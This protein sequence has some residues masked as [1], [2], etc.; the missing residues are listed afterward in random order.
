MSET[1][2]PKAKRAKK[3][4][5]AKAVLAQGGNRLP[6]RIRE[7]ERILRQHV[8]LRKL[9]SYLKASLT[10]AEAYA[11]VEC[12]GPHLFQGTTGKLY[13]IHPP[14]AYLEH[15]S[16]WGEASPGEGT[17]PFRD[18]WALRRAQPHWVRDAHAEPFCG[19]VTPAS[20]SW[21]CKSRKMPPD[22]AM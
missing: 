8:S 1:A 6:H 22:A 10:P 3:R 20:K 21:M 17:F 19:H 11:A 4:E 14:G 5:R 16:T 12:F 7:L 2:K 15:V 18:C 13:L 9:S